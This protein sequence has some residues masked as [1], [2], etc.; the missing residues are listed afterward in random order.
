MKSRHQKVQQFAS[1]YQQRLDSSRS[2]VA[3]LTGS[4][5]R[6]AVQAHSSHVTRVQTSTSQTTRTRSRT[7]VRDL[8][9]TLRASG[10]PA[11]DG[12]GTDAGAST[13][14][15]PQRRF[16]AGAVMMDAGIG[17]GSGSGTPTQAGSLR[18]RGSRGDGVE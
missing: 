1:R 11:A 4:A 5:V 12:D 8:G 13:V 7:A 9:T 18:P 2:N 14:D 6:Q 16:E 15:A 17:S 10:L 3:Q